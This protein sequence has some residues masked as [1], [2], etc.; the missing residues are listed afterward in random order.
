MK[1]AKSNRTFCC[2]DGVAIKA[3]KAVKFPGTLEGVTGVRAYI[4]ANIII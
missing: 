3:F 1:T 4:A 2:G